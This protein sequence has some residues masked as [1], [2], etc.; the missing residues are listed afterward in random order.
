M[1][2]AAVLG[3][4]AALLLAPAGSWASWNFAA[5][6]STPTGSAACGCWP[7]EPCLAHTGAQCN[8]PRRQQ[9]LLATIELHRAW[10]NCLRSACVSC[11]ARQSA[12]TYYFF[13]A[14]A[15]RAPWGLQERDHTSMVSH[16]SRCPGV[17]HCAA[18]CCLLPAILCLH[19]YILPLPCKHHVAHTEVASCRDHDGDLMITTEVCKVAITLFARLVLRDRPATLAGCSIGMQHQGIFLV[20]TVLEFASLA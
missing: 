19:Y 6:F 13:E 7:M 20:S 11:P 18:A 12:F 4:L 3:C 17:S 15:A 10:G 14:A 8:Q 1:G 9:N 16:L 5:G 2:K